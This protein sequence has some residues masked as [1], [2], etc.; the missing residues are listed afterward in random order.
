MMVNSI[1]WIE[2]SSFADDKHD[3]VSR[4]DYVYYHDNIY[5]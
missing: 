2:P 5:I 3:F 4:V 1:F